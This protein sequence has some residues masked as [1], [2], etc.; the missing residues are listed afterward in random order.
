M[1]RIEQDAA[2]ELVA[3]EQQRKWRERVR[4]DIDRANAPAPTKTWAPVHAEQQKQ[5]QAEYIKQHNCPF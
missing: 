2:D 1:N 3:H 5:Q 4:D